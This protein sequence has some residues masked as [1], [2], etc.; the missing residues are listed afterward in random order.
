[1][2]C[3]TCY[4]DINDWM[5]GRVNCKKELEGSDYCPVCTVKIDM[6]IK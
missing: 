3:R 4:R 5:T 1:M 2:I 6:V